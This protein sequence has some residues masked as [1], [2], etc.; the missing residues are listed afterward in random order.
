M[1]NPPTGVTG[2]KE[3]SETGERAFWQ[4][5]PAQMGRERGKRGGL[6]PGGEPMGPAGGIEPVRRMLGQPA[7]E[8]FAG[9]GGVLVGVNLAG[10]HAA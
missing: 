9:C 3:A 7:G 6:P 2:G 8:L 1:G 4:S 10:R 5:R